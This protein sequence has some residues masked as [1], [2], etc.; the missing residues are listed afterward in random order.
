MQG[1]V[2][3]MA[4]ADAL[5]GNQTYPIRVRVRVREAD[6]LV[7]RSPKC[8]LHPL[9]WLMNS[10]NYNA[11]VLTTPPLPCHCYYPSA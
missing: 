3:C 9:Q 4:E 8:F 11:I 6:A 2:K 10:D 1:R 5:V 7:D